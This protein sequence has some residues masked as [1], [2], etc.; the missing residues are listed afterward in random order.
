MCVAT[1]NPPK[2][3]DGAQQVLMDTMLF[4]KHPRLLPA[5]GF[6]TF[7]YYNVCMASIVHVYWGK[8]HENIEIRY[9]ARANYICM[10]D[11]H[12]HVYCRLQG[13]II[14]VHVHVQVILWS[15]CVF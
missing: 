6:S 13:Y 14:H 10:Y 2:V 1:G 3:P 4:W 11:V 5:C 12:V 8:L 15:M 9:V 7:H